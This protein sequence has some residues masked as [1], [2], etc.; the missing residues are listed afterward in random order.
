VLHWNG[1]AWKVVKTFPDSITQGAETAPNDVWV[2]GEGGLDNA[3]YYNGRTWTFEGN[4]VDGGS[5]LAA[6]NAWGFVGTFV[7][8]WPGHK[9]VATNVASLLPKK[10]AANGP[11]VTGIIALSNTNVY[12]FGNGFANSGACGPTVILHFDGRTWRRVAQGTF[13]C[14]PLVQTAVPDGLGGLWLPMPDISSQPSYLVHYL[15]GKLTQAS[16]PGSFLQYEIESVAHFPGT[17]R[18]LAGGVRHK[19]GNPNASLGA[20]ILQ[21]S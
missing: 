16:L 15:N 5:V 17:T 12:A 21:Y 14:G 19:Q 8:H 18:S 13:G 3:Y 11:Q 10:T 6:N 2:F 7:E 1:H 20:V 9:W 4:D